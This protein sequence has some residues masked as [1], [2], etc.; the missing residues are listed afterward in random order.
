MTRTMFGCVSAARTNAQLATTPTRRMSNH[1]RLI[2]IGGTLDSGRIQRVLEYRVVD[3]FLPLRQARA[4][5]VAHL[6]RG[7][8]AVKVLL[9][10]RVILQVKQLIQAVGELVT[11]EFPAIG[12][13]H[14]HRSEAAVV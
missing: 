6:L 13:D 3:G 14:P 4:E 5:L 12:P 9:L 8:I 1:V 11:H 2:R 10:A 7:L